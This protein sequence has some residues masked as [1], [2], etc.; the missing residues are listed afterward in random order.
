MATV[1]QAAQAAYEAYTRA[2]G[3]VA[4]NGD[5]LPDWETQRRHNPRLADAW[6][7]AAQAAVTRSLD[8]VLAPGEGTLDLRAERQ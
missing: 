5:V 6:R 7:A 2:V 1:D 8:A 4:F 3:G